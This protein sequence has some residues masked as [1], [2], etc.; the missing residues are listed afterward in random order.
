MEII[1]Y[2]VCYEA[3]SGEIMTRML[4]FLHLMCVHYSSK[5]SQ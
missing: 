3:M 5:E 4:S 2:C 1:F